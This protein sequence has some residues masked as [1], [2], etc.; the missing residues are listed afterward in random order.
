M[1]RDTP[2]R[3]DR[4]EAGLASP[5]EDVGWRVE[6]LTVTGDNSASGMLVEDR[7]AFSSVMQ[8][9]VYTGLALASAAAFLYTRVD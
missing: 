8:V 6:G 9:L 4:V 2:A 5:F 1:I 7:A 3:T